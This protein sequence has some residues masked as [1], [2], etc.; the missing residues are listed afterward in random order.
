LLTQEDYLSKWRNWSLP[1]PELVG[2]K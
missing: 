1:A 2:L